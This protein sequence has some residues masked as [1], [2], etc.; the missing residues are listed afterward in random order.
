MLDIKI[1]RE[2]PDKIKKGVADKQLDSSL[3]DEVL[4]L[5]E[6]RRELL[7][8]IEGLRAEKNKLSS[9]QHVVSSKGKEIKDELKRLEPEL[10][11][12]EEEFKRILCQIPNLPADDVKV[13]KDESENEVIRKWGDPPTATQ[14]GRAGPKDHLELGEALDIIDVKRAAKVSGTRFGYLKGDA[15]LLEF[16]LVQFALETLIPEG[17]TPIVPPTLIK[18]ESMAGMGYLEHGGEEDMYV[19]E[20]DNLVLVGTAEQSIG[21]M[22]GGELLKA[23]NL[24][25]RYVAFSSCFRREAGSYGKDTRGI[26]RVHQFDKAEMFSYAKPEEGDKEHEY[27]L[28]LEERL[29][30]ALGL[31]YQVVKMC[32]GDLGAP[33]ARKYDLEAW[34]PSQNKYRELTSASTCTDFQSRRLN[35]KYQD[36]GEKKFVHTLNGT[37][38]AIGRTI[39]AIMENYQ[40]K[41]GSIVVPE[42]L[43]KWV[44]KDIVTVRN[45]K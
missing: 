17:F 23:E 15:V 38:F 26:F 19:L 22:H 39:I 18:K 27:L 43:R 42:V 12:V 29:L 44:G 40:Q 13:G 11:K 5:D 25:L 6:K 30:Q 10:R 4:K 9:K 35:I 7:N 24:P 31:P 3:V 37:A 20:K 16:A 2:N 45:T 41:D 28:G 1:I 32:T 21:P 34:I 36:K 33:A 8:E 14:F